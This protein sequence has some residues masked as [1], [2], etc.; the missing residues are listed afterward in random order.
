MLRRRIFNIYIHIYVYDV[1]P[2]RSNRCPPDWELCMYIY[3]YIYT[4]DIAC[5]NGLTDGR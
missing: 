1:H 3:I 4:N 5:S 2:V